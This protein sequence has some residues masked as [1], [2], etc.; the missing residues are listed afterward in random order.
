M[1]TSL[2]GTPRLARL[3]ESE[4]LD[5]ANAYPLAEFLNDL[6]ADVFAGAAPD[7]NRRTLQRVYVERLAAIIN[8]PPP[9]T[10][11]AGRHAAAGTGHADSVRDRAERAA[12]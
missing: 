6:K 2:L 10:L 4:E 1:I 3:A 7:A 5:A 11:P 8:P 12:K 9:P